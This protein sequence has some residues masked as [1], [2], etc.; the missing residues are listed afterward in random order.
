MLYTQKFDSFVKITHLNHPPTAAPETLHTK[1]KILVADD[2]AFVLDSV[3][4]LLKKS[5]YTFD[6]YDNATEA[7]A[8]LQASADIDVVLTDF[9]MPD[10]S[11]IEFL[12]KIRAFNPEIPVI[13]MTAYAE[14]NIAIN[15]I[16]RGVFDFL[17]KPFQPDQLYHTIKKAVKYYKLTQLEK[18]YT[19]TLENMVS[20]KTKELA[21]A[22]E[23]NRKMSSEL[24]QRLSL[25][26]EYRDFKTG[27]H[28]SKL[29]L[30]TERIS[31]VLGLPGKFTKTIQCASAMHDI[32]KIGIPDEIL[33]KNGLLCHEEFETMKKHTLIGEKILSGSSY[34]T[35]QMSASIALNHHERWN[36]TGYPRGLKGED[37]PIEGRITTICDQYDALRSE[38]PYKSPCTHREAFEILTKGD[39]KTMPEHFDPKVLNAFIEVASDFNDIF[40]TKHPW[41]DQSQG[42]KKA[43]FLNNHEQYINSR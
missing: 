43:L 22:L 14:L 28:I 10:V 40:H 42:R 24:I 21:N 41:P 29:G 26:T 3:S 27:A 9:Q 6:A 1:T 19:T 18:N 39:G 4:R 20:E 8:K 15:A 32:G 30:Y 34:F 16:K 31:H 38:R 5:G 12:E 7:L 37:I 13:I 25:A 36:G 35:I 33:L 11:G 17:L 23:I 2:D